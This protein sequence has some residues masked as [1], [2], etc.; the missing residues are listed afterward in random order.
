MNLGFEGWH[1][2]SPPALPVAGSSALRL[3]SSAPLP[4]RDDATALRPAPTAPTP[5]PPGGADGGAPPGS[6]QPVRAGLQASCSRLGFDP[7][8]LTLLLSS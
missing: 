4:L 8:Q 1:A 6:A 7:V 3:P 2:D 5:G